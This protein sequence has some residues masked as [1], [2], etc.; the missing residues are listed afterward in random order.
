MPSSDTTPSQ[1][2]VP[3][4]RDAYRAFRAIQTRWMDNDIY[5][6]MNNTVPVP[7]QHLTQTPIYYE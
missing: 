5:G 4:R 3:G 2:A 7:H 1:R 6:H